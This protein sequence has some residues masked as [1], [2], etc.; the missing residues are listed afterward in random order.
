MDSPVFCGESAI[1][2]FAQLNWVDEALFSIPTELVFPD[3]LIGNFGIMGITVHIKL[4]RVVDDSSN[5][6]WKS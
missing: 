2:D 6:L 4:A 5:R 3:K 1:E